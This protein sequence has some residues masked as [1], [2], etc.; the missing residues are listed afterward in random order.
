MI[1]EGVCG[2][3]NGRLPA[4]SPAIFVS[5]PNVFSRDYGQC[6]KGPNKPAPL[7]HS[8]EEACEEEA[9]EEVEAPFYSSSFPRKRESSGGAYKTIRCF[10]CGN[11]RLDSRFRG[12]DEV[13][14]GHYCLSPRHFFGAP[15]VIMSAARFLPTLLGRKDERK[16]SD[17]F[18]CAPFCAVAGAGAN[19]LIAEEP[20][21]LWRRS[22][23][24]QIFARLPAAGAAGMWRT[25]APTAIMKT[26]GRRRRRLRDAP[27]RPRK[28]PA[29]ANGCGAEPSFDRIEPNG[30]ESRT[31]A[32]LRRTLRP[33]LVSGR[34]RVEEPYRMA[35]EFPHAH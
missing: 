4:W 30:R 32:A 35:C 21:A 11:G 24:A 27:S 3:A 26:T 7:R 23:G 22:V 5:A 19:D 6:V 25:G 14:L 15:T 8:C 17:Q 29:P 31:L 1:D 33:G 20:R 34:S 13:L 9:C 2:E 16:L 18:F 12:N 28:P 10:S